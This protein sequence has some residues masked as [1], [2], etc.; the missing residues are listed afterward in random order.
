M[1]P[2]VSIAAVLL[3]AF[4]QFE[5]I[6]AGPQPNHLHQVKIEGTAPDEAIVVEVPIDASQERAFEM[7]EAEGAALLNRLF[8]E[9]NQLSSED[10]QR[11]KRPNGA[12]RFGKSLDL[13][14]EFRLYGKRA[15]QSARR[16]GKSLDLL[17]EFRLY[18][19]RVGQSARRFGKSLD[20][21]DEFRLYGK[22]SNRAPSRFGTSFDLLDDFRFYGKLADRVPSLIPTRAPSQS[23]ASQ[24]AVDRKAS[25]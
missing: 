1:N 24:S 6:R 14:D 22:R 5:A 21:L 11:S 23:S 17:D 8:A 25:I 3:A 7:A 10:T 18:G 20:L 12:R 2:V 19:K 13:L 9:Q 16:F 4:L 15:G